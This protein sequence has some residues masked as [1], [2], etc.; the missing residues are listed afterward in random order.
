MNS[1]RIEKVTSRDDRKKFI[2]FPWKVYKNNPN[3]VPPL[4]MDFKEK[5]NMEKNPF[6]EHAEMELFLAYRDAGITGRIAAIVDN[7]HNSF[8][9]EK[10]VFFGL[11]ESFDDKDTAKTLLDTVEKWGK[12]KGME[13]LR[14]PM[15][16]SM[17]DECAF[18]LEGFDSPPVIMMP[19]NPEYYL[20]LMAEGGLVK[21]KD[22]YAFYMSREAT[23]VAWIGRIVAKTKAEI[24]FTLRTIDMK[25]LKK[26]AA[27]IKYVYNNAWEKNWGFGRWVLVSSKS[28]GTRVSV[29]CFIQNSIKIPEQRVMSGAKLPGNWKIMN[30]SIDSLNH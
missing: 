18:L 2:F 25:N 16:I 20:G 10:V 7:N 17:N 19:Y 12:E 29:T 30:L 14:G 15:N 11:Y 27:S 21:A 4:V 22:L 8:H 23:V 1:I 3:W 26:E 28:S 6:F 24:P 13:I 9:D 5:I